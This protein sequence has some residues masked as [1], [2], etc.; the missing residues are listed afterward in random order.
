[1]ATFYGSTSEAAS[2]SGVLEANLTAAM[3]KQI[4]SWIENRIYNG[5]TFEEHDVTDEFYDIGDPPPGDT[6]VRQLILRNIPII[7]ITSIT[8]DARGS[9]PTVVNSGAYVLDMNGESGIVRLETKNVT[10]TD[11]IDG[12]T[13]G[14]HAVKVTYKWGFTTPPTK[15]AELATLLLAKWGEVNEQQSEADGLKEVKAGD[16]TEKYDLTFLNV[17]TKYD[18]EIKMLF[19]ELKAKYYNFV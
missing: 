10:G 2:L 4:N 12:F 13:R 15:I 17:R 5:D 19:N 14:V 7:S 16:Y 9:S 8:D 1:M 11:V 6:L 18:A 3:Q